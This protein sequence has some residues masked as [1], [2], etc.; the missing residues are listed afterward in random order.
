MK[1]SMTF[2]AILAAAL[3]P[4]CRSTGEPTDAAVGTM[5]GAMVGGLAGRAIGDHNGHAAAGT[6]AGAGLGALVGGLAGAL[7]DAKRDTYALRQ[8]PVFEE[9]DLPPIPRPRRVVRRVIVV[10]RVPVYQERYYCIDD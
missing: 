5:A 10:R 1:P 9:E 8:G 6:W 2:A 4:G 3:A 7:S